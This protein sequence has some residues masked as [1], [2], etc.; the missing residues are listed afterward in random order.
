MSIVIGTLIPPCPP[1]REVNGVKPKSKRTT[2]VRAVDFDNDEDL[3][4]K[5][6][7]NT[8]YTKNKIPPKICNFDDDEVEEK[9]PQK[10]EKIQP[11]N[12]SISKKK[13]DSTQRSEEQN[14]DNGEY[15]YKS[16]K[17]ISKKKLSTQ[18]RLQTSTP[19]KKTLS[20]QKNNAEEENINN[21][22]NDEISI[23]DYENIDDDEFEEQFISNH[24]KIQKTIPSQQQKK[25]NS[26]KKIGTNT[27]GKML[28]NKKSGSVPKPYEY[29]SLGKS[30]LMNFNSSIYNNK[31]S[32]TKKENSNTNGTKIGK[33]YGKSNYKYKCKR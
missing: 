24:Q 1:P 11:K 13:K 4:I 14:E 27:Q 26:R 25:I 31:S 9:P 12:K 18:K 17:P 5:P 21:E 29:G 3:P 8:K 20:Y 22:K 19:N 32:S 6:Q 33:D 10:V 15:Y 2:H 16:S 23:D 28:N 7:Q 30:T